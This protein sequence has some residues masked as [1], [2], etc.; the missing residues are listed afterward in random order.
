MSVAVLFRSRRF[1]KR[2]AT[3]PPSCD[4][5][6][7]IHR[8]NGTIAAVDAQGR[9]WRLNIPQRSKQE[10]IDALNAPENCRH[11]LG[12]N[13]PFE[14]LDVRPWTRPLCRGGG[15]S[16]CAASFL[17]ATRPISTGRAGGFG[18]N[19]GVGDA[20]GYRLEVGGGTKVGRR[21]FARQLH[22]GCKPIAMINDQRSCR[23]CARGYDNQT[24]SSAQDRGR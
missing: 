9:V 12:E 5:M 23:E 14:L 13:I 6:S 17:L 15:I 18:M 11:A 16:G 19:T 8:I 21:A 2:S 4:Q 1:S 10:Q 3:A 22:P 20:V 7:S 24:P